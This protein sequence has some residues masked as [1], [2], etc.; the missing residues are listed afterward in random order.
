MVGHQVGQVGVIIWHPLG[1][2]I[3][4]IIFNGLLGGD[5]G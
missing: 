5:L 3:Q 1:N 2:H 4:L